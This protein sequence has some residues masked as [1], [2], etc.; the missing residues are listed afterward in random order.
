MSFAKQT[1]CAHV[2]YYI[3]FFPGGV[4]MDQCRRLIGTVVNWRLDFC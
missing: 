4:A 2:V 1:A 3:L